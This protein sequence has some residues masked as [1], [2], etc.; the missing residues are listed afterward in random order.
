MQDVYARM[1]AL[2]DEMDFDFSQFTMERFAAWVQERHDRK[3]RF[4]RWE[5]PPGMFG[6]WMSD[7]EEPV[8]HVFIDKNA[9][10]LQAAHIQLHE[11]GHILCG[12]PT[13]RLTV[14]EMADLLT[15][16]V[17]N[18]AVL[19]E[20]LLRAP[21]KGEWEQE[22]ETLAALI[23]DQVIRHQRL[24]QL[25]VSASSNESVV[26]HFKALELV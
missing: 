5:M 14:S 15:K 18:P 6:V 13:A 7:A 16:S 20:A 12:H 17:T 22:A 1:K 3:I 2:L 19:E 25:A 11:L 4:T 23:Q 26:A 10:P 9:P 8:E 24:Q 21:N